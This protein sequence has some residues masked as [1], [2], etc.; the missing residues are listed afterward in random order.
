M[1][2]F[3]YFWPLFSKTQAKFYSVFWSHF[4]RPNF[5]HVF[6][7]HSLNECK[8]SKM[9]QSKL[10]KT[11]M[12]VTNLLGL[13]LRCSELEIRR[14]IIR[15]LVFCKHVVSPDVLTRVTV[16]KYAAGLVHKSNCACIAQSL[17]NRLQNV[18]TNFFY[19]ALYLYQHLW[20]LKGK[21]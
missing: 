10:G 11:D 1:Q 19:F 15:Q 20:L 6:F 3:W 5:L 13:T 16:G 4:K 12:S 18:L 9:V 2:I 14:G 17:I 8:Y 21:Q 7:E